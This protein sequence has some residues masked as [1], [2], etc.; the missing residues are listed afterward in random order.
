MG[1]VYQ[2]NDAD[3]NLHAGS[4]SAGKVTICHSS[5]KL[6]SVDLSDSDSVIML[7]I[8]LSFLPMKNPTYEEAVTVNIRHNADR[9][10]YNG[11]PHAL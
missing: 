8:R 5:P 7:V 4:A 2:T 1:H 10:S 6:R 11:V 3:R 9:P